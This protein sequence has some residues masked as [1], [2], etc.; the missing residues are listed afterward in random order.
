MEMIVDALGPKCLV[1][2]S[3]HKKDNQEIRMPPSSAIQSSCNSVLF[4]KRFIHTTLTAKSVTTVA[5]MD[6]SS[7]LVSVYK[8]LRFMDSLTYKFL[9]IGEMIIAYFFDFFNRFDFL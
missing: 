6:R 9:W 1:I 8:L 2:I 3:I 7:I 4:A 5:G